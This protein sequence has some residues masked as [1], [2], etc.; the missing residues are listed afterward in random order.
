MQHSQH[1][2]TCCYMPS[3]T[4]EHDVLALF[5]EDARLMPAQSS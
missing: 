3:L 2:L 1:G 4:E 5:T